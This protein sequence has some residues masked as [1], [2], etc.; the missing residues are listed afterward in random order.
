MGY[1]LEGV[2]KIDVHDWSPVHVAFVHEPAYGTDKARIVSKCTGLG[3]DCAV[4]MNASV[5]TGHPILLNH[6]GHPTYHTVPD[7]VDG[8]IAKAATEEDK[9]KVA[10][11]YYSELLNNGGTTDVP[12][13]CEITAALKQ[14]EARARLVSLERRIMQISASEEKPKDK[15]DVDERGSKCHWVDITGQKVPSVRRHETQTVGKAVRVGKERGKEI[16]YFLY[17]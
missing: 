7:N 9:E 1:T 15:P 12:M 4:Q 17:R 10:Q 16:K 11:A 8:R 13:D 3:G 5:K 14:L 2:P 6:H